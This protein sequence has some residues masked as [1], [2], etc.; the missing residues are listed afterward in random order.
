[1]PSIVGIK[2]TERYWYFCSS[3]LVCGV[4][5]FYY[6]LISFGNHYQG[7]GLQPGNRSQES[8]VWVKIYCLWEQQWFH[9]CGNKFKY[10]PYFKSQLCQVTL[11]QEKYWKGICNLK[12]W[13]S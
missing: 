13:I 8:E 7:S 10:D 9:N 5:K 4:L 11:L 1:M 6:R 2:D 3:L 12:D